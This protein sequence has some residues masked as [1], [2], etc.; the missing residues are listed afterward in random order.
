MRTP[1]L[2]WSAFLTVSLVIPWLISEIPAKHADFAA[3][4]LEKSS[5]Q[6]EDLHASVP[7][8]MAAD[9]RVTVPATKNF[10]FLIP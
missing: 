7:V 1:R 8:S 5:V 6:N 4:P 3:V 9:A 2:I 10:T